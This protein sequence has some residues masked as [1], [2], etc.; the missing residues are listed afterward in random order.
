[1]VE[2]YSLQEYDAATARKIASV[3]Y[4]MTRISFS[5]AIPYTFADDVPVE[6][7]AKIKE[8][9]NFFIGVDVEIVPYRE[10]SDGTLLPHVLGRVGLIS[11]EEYAEK[12]ANGEEYALNA[13]IGKDG[14]EAAMEEYLRGT[15]AVSYTH[16]TLPTMAV[17]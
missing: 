15:R 10:Y 16:L 5:T 3:R 12:K 4:E 2:K 9:S 7:V 8:N 14:I 11:A 6:T 1:M 17:V 13:V